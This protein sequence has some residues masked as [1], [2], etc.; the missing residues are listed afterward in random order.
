MYGDN[1]SYIP[2]NV[3]K[4]FAKSLKAKEV[5]IDNDGHLNEEAGYNSFPELLKEIKKRQV[6]VLLPFGYQ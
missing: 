4:E 6:V 1:D 3:L 2:Q 5:I